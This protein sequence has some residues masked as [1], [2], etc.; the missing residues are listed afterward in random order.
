[1]E[2]LEL[3]LSSLSCI[4][5]W[6]FS[7]SVNSLTSSTASSSVHS[8]FREWES[9]IVKLSHK[10][11]SGWSGMTV[12]KGK[13]PANLRQTVFCLQNYCLKPKM[14]IKNLVL[15]EILRQ[16]FGNSLGCWR[17]KQRVLLTLRRKIC[18]R[19]VCYM[20]WDEDQDVRCDLWRITGGKTRVFSPQVL[21]PETSPGVLDLQVSDKVSDWIWWSWAVKLSSWAHGSSPQVYASDSHKHNIYTSRWYVK[22]GGGLILKNELACFLPKC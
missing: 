2:S 7:S 21:S 5:C 11:Y 6:N 20:V 17:L 4:S 14:K 22:G 13:P 3:D 19:R 12:R 10:V 15:A 1:M 9:E 16:K 8:G 18:G